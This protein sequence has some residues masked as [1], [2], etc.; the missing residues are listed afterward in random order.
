MS[1]AVYLRRLSEYLGI[2]AFVLIISSVATL[3]EDCRDTLCSRHLTE[4][5]PMGIFFEDKQ[6]LTHE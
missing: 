6:T 1:S 3:L 4:L 5:I 2:D